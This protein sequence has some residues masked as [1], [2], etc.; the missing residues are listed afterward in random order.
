M[1]IDPE[2]VAALIAEIA[3]EHIEPRYQRLQDEEIRT[4]TGPNDFVTEADI[5]AESALKKALC[6]LCPGSAFVGEEAASHDASVFGELEREGALWI[7]DPLDG[8]RNFVEGRPEFGTIVAY[9]VNGQICMGWI[10][11]IPDGKCAIAELGAGAMYGAE[12]L[13]E[14]VETPER[15]TGYRGV[16]S[17]PTALRETVTKNLREHTDTQPVRCSAYAYINLARG[18]K[19]FA[20]YSRAYPWDHAAG[21]LIMNEIGGKALYLDAPEDYAL[22][23]SLGRPFLVGASKD[24]WHRSRDIVVHGRRT[25]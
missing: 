5:A 9:V 21:V 7:V 2:H 8:T 10:Y 16:G 24:A 1:S 18:E 15:L 3:A 20:I 11:A 23:P 13:A 14:V 19:D 22:A 6:G 4:K 17:L 12:R 25:D